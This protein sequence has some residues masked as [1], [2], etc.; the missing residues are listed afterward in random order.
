MEETDKNINIETTKSEIKIS[1]P[2]SYNTE[3]NQG[4]D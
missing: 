4:V 1:K 3:K 2:D